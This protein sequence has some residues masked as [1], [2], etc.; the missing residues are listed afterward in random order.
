MNKRMNNELAK[1]N[2]EVIGSSVVVAHPAKGHF[3]A[4]TLSLEPSHQQG[5]AASRTATH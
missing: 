3:C 1:D 5:V 2:T 4:E